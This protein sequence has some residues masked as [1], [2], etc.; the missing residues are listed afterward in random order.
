MHVTA[1]ANAERNLAAAATPKSLRK[2]QSESAGGSR[3]Q[4]E[5]SCWRP[6]QSN[7]LGEVALG[8]LHEV[9]TSNLWRLA[10]PLCNIRF[11]EVNPYA[12]T[13]RAVRQLEANQGCAMSGR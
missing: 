5:R 1:W 8:Q 2:V 11:L 9:H 10:A 12:F 7:G 4:S 3:Q 13:A 6:W